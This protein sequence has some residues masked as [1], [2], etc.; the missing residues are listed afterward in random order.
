[1]VCPV[2]EMLIMKKCFYGHLKVVNLS[3]KGLKKLE[4]DNS[5]DVCS[6]GITDIWHVVDPLGYCK[7]KLH[8]PNLS[9]F[10][11][12]EGLT[13]ISRF[14]M[15]KDSKYVKFLKGLSGARTLAL[16]K[17]VFLLVSSHIHSSLSRL[18]L[19][20]PSAGC[21]G[22]VSSLYFRWYGK[23]ETTRDGHWKEVGDIMKE[24]PNSQQMAMEVAVGSP[25]AGDDAI[26][27]QS[28]ED[29]PA[30]DRVPPRTE[31]ESETG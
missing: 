30:L 17:I 8:T 21:G 14:A 18:V 27:L 12:K 6:S 25:I 28:K 2:L 11:Y 10:V 23:R 26:F 13:G 29:S 7:L 9:T 15:S 19:A 1:M 5:E 20:F 31:G 22:G 3:L 24:E 4:I 16:M